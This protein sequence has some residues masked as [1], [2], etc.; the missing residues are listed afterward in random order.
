MKSWQARVDVLQDNFEDD[1]RSEFQNNPKPSNI[2]NK[3]PDNIRTSALFPNTSNV[4][5]SRTE[6]PSA[7]PEE[8]ILDNSFNSNSQST[9]SRQHAL[10]TYQSSHHI[11]ENDPP[12]SYAEIAHK[13]K[14]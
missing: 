10:R 14:K 1:I 8:L 5:E 7:P 9:T 6:T 13:L 3:L 2:L 12:P 11:S 4:V